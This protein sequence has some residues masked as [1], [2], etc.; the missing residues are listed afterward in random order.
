MPAIF[1]PF[2]AMA[3]FAD[4][5][6][7]SARLQQAWLTASQ[8]PQAIERLQAS[9]LR[10]LVSGA[11]MRSPYYRERLAG[12]PED[13][14]R[15]DRFPVQDKAGL[16]ARFDDWVTD[17]A[18]RFEEIRRFVADPGRVGEPYLGRYAVW[19]SSGSTGTPGIYVQDPD[20]LAVYDALLSARFPSAAGSPSPFATLAGGG[21]FA[22]VAALEG[23]F[24]GVVSWERL[25]RLH[26]WMAAATRSFSVLSPL[27]ELVSD[28]QSWQPT[29]VA[30]YPTTLLLLAGERRAGRLALAPQV[31][32]SGG[33]TL[34]DGERAEIADAFGCPVIDGYGSS[35]CMQI[36][37]DCGHGFLHLNSDWVVLEP[38]D[39]HGQAV[40]PGTA[41]QTVL[42]TNLANHVQPLI[43]YD[44]GDSVTMLGHACACGS[45]FPAL[46]VSGR[47]DDILA[48]E[49]EDG[50]LVRLAPLAVATVIEEGG[51]VRRFQLIQTG[52]AAL[53]VRF[54]TPQ[55]D[56][57]Q[58]AL[59]C[60][61][62][63]LRAYF[64]HQ[65]LH[66]IDIVEDPEP[67][68]ADPVSGKLREVLGMQP[69][70]RQ[71]RTGT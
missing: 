14:F 1:D 50:R 48:L 70:G 2:A 38:V 25:R 13:E 5:W 53:A 11:R 66:R 58:D 56:A 3:A 32:W 10:A 27:A 54:E 17:P 33:E 60:I 36:A 71:D 63:A 31:L 12:M 9:R 46:R 42:L 65:G 59:G 20:A 6:R 22:M 69:Q 57:R 30:A 29:V 41:S 4:F 35:E 64:A 37:H 55:G 15:L 34:S 39:E 52:P 67:P 44:L 61:L 19:T 26:P 40:P 18:L 47:R 28:L 51:G 24:A 16:M 68:R 23:H 7:W 43:R 45:P 49:A 62:T 21:R 8:T